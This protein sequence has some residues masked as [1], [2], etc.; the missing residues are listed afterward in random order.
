MMCP[1]CMAYLVEERPVCPYCG[2]TLG[3]QSEEDGLQSLR[4]GKRAREMKAAGAAV[5]TAPRHRAGRGASRAYVAGDAQSTKEIPIYGDAALMQ[6]PGVSGDTFARYRQTRE[7]AEQ[8]GRNKERYTT[9]RRT[10]QVKQHMVNWSLMAIIGALAVVMLIVGTYAYLTRTSNGQKIMA[11]MGQES[12]SIA[13]WEVGKEYMNSG[14]VE[15]AIEAFEKARLQDGEE[16]V[17]VDGLLNLGGAYEA[18]DR[19]AD[20]EAVYTELFTTIVPTRAEPYTETIRIML[21]QSRE[22]EAADLMQ[23]AFEMTGQN[24]FR[25]QRMELLPSAPMVDLVAGLY[26]QKRKLTLVSAEGYDIYY[27]FDETAELPAGGVKY[28]SPIQLDEGIFALRAV[29]VND[30][31]ISDE[32]H[33]T[34]KIIMPSPQTPRSSLAP[35]TY[36]QRQRIWLKPGLDNEKD[37]DITIYYTI[38]GSMPD[39]DSPVYTGEP[40]YLPGGRVTLHAIA[41]NGYNKVSNV[42]EIKYKIEAKPYPLTAYDPAEDNLGS[43]ALNKTTRDAFQEEYGKGNGS[44]KVTLEGFEGECEKFTYDWGYAVMGKTKN[45]WALV[46]LYFTSERFKAP[47][48]TGIGD[49]ESFI[50]GKYRDMGQVESPSGNR[51]LYAD[52]DDVGKIFKQEDGGKIIRYRANTAD[53]HLWQLEYHIDKG[54]TCFAVKWTYED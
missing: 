24:L 52:G 48:G 54:G 11:R 32:L 5:R 43:L 33:G 10:H 38:D 49:K 15:K 8:N 2:T 18:A 19:V 53:S 4:Q 37:T 25:Q 50:V 3:D 41:V 23:R 39:A 35:N 36:K 17:N 45:T 12:T 42:L 30:D 40:F 34:Y 29:A 46:E 27:T 16:N 9:G 14:D 6:Q 1:K 20:A 7:R 51:G 26:N 44:E 21:A 31:L 28:E 13:L 47:R 22:P